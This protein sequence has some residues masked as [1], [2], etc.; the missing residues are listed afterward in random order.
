MILYLELLG[1]SPYN[2][3]R[4]NWKF[5]ENFPSSHFGEKNVNVSMKAFVDISI[6]RSVFSG[7]NFAAIFD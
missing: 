6:T 5:H 7:R 1:G 4:R 3:E 2:F